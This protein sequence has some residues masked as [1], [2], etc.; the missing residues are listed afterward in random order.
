MVTVVSETPGK[1]E[2]I[3]RRITLICIAIT[4]GISGIAILGWM[5]DMLI[6]TRVSP[7]YIPMAPSTAIS[8]FIL[9]VALFVYTHKREH[10][11]SNN[12]AKIGTILIFLIT[13]IILVEFLTGSEFNIESLLLPNPEKFGQVSMGRMSPL[14]AID[15]ILASSSLLLLLT[16]KEGKQRT[17]GL[18]TILATLVFLLGFIYVLGY[19]Y[20]TPLLYGGTVIPVAFTT[21]IAFV[22]LGIGLIGSTG[23]EYWPISL[24]IGQSVYARLMRGFLPALVLLILIHGWLDITLHH[25]IGEENLFSTAILAV[26]SAIVIWILISKISKKIGGDIDRA[27]T[28]RKEA[29]DKFASMAKTA[30]D[31][32]IIAD[33]NDNIIFWNIGAEKT[34]H[35]TEKETVGKP[36]TVIMPERYRDAHKKG[37]KRILE[38]EKSKYVGKTIE[39]EGIRKDGSEF[40]VE[41]SVTHWKMGSEMFFGG[42]LH[43]I[44]ERK[45]FEELEIEN[46]SLALTNK[47]KSEFLSVMSH[48]LRTPLNASIGFSELL[49]MGTVGELNEKQENYVDKIISSSKHLNELIGEILDLTQIEAGKM[50]LNIENVSLPHFIEENISILNV[51]ARKRNVLIKK[52]IAPELDVIE[53]DKQRLRQIISNL[54]DNAVKFSKEEG[55]TVTVSA[56]KEEDIVRISVSDTGIGIK[57]EDIGKLF[58]P[59]KQLNMGYTREQGGTGLGLAI[60]KQLVELH[61]GKIWVESKYGEGSTFIF[62]LPINA[63]KGEN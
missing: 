17:K 24:F 40:P 15:F 10:I 25:Y 48:E 9:S 12:L 54:V 57:E 58:T 59:F 55:G 33:E 29:E 45:K 44:T 53:C 26:L 56:K 38:G 39:L 4:A 21:A 37:L 13:L 7:E 23:G 31:A 36:L 35:Y 27:N 43:D 32:I 49:K 19:L 16:S 34:F 42:I 3:F 18:A 63:I 41:F 22:F 51:L 47:T 62:T 6:V 14:T 30:I 1:D 11:F 5:L 50:E 2:N 28:R 20:G 46:K 61:G 8:F 60:T 52:D